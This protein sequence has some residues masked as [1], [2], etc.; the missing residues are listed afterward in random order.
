[1]QGECTNIYIIVHIYNIVY[2]YT[3]ANI[4]SNIAIFVCV[5]VYA[6]TA[7]ASIG[8]KHDARGFWQFE[9]DRIFSGMKHSHQTL[10]ATGCT[11]LTGQ[12]SIIVY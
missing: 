1:M 2:S 4:S 3:I 12:L 8:G 10:D 5:S 11:E 9:I 6:H 7:Y